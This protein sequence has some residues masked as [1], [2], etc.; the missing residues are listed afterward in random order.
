MLGP[1]YKNLLIYLSFNGIDVFIGFLILSLITG[2]IT[3][4]EYGKVGLL[5]ALLV[6]IQPI[7]GH[8]VGPLVQVKRNFLSDSDFEKFL[9][10]V[11]IL[12]FIGF[13]GVELILI[14]FTIV[15]EELFGIIAFVIPIICLSRFLVNVRLQEFTID[16]RSV[17]FGLSRL[18]PKLWTVSSLLLFYFIDLPVRSN[19]YILII[20]VSEIF[21]LAFLIASRLEL[22][23]KISNLSRKTIKE[24]IYFG[25]PII[26]ATVPLWILNEYGKIIL[27]DSLE[28][29]GLFT[30]AK[31]LSLVY[32]VACTS[33]SNTFVSKLLSSFKTIDIL[34]YF[35]IYLIIYVVLIIIYFLSFEKL[36]PSLISGEYIGVLEIFRLLLLGC[37][38]QVNTS[39]AVQILSREGKTLITLISALVSGMFFLL[40]CYIMF[41]NITVINVTYSYV[42]SM[43]IYL[44]VIWIF[45]YYYILRLQPFK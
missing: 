4:E 17:K 23:L 44:S 33:V 35:F 42:G 27:D 37:F 36:S 41:E 1:M 11:Y 6:F 45:T 39:V 20:M 24:I 2:T 14:V 26:F 9:S 12:S 34:K 29:V 18:G 10:N 40:S 3:P 25:T 21:V 31:Q 7:I 28:A 32:V 19:A 43:F 5:F 30:L 22:F 15:H 16:G 13:I 38:F 8:S